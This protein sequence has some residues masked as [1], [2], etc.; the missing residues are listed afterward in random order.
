MLGKLK[1][2]QNT[3]E[4]YDENTVQKLWLTHVGMFNISKKLNETTFKFHG[5]CW[6]I[7]RGFRVE[8]VKVSTDS[9]SADFSLRLYKCCVSQ[10]FDV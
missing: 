7:L 1:V 4:K 8:N 5:G 6:M 10:T 3:L 9:N 2:N